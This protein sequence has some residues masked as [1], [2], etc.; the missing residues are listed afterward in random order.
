MFEL[1][2]EMIRRLRKEQDKTQVDVAEESG[3]TNTQISR[4]EGGHQTP[5][6]DTL[7]K[8]LT[9]LGLSRIEFIYRYE[10]MEREYLRR[11]AEEQGDEPPRFPADP[12]LQL[13]ALLS[14][15]P[16]GLERGHLELG[17]Y[18]ILIFPKPQPK[19]R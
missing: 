12:F 4:I 13:P 15:M 18:V 9:A 11:R 8:I 19:P 17:D 10:A 5:S 7:G 3:C 6:L 1:I 14:A 16:P 2:P